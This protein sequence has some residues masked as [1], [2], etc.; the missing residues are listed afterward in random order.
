MLWLAA[1][2]NLIASPPSY[3]AN[4]SGRPSLFCLWRTLALAVFDDYDPH[5]RDSV[6]WFDWKRWAELLAHAW[7]TPSLWGFSW[8]WLPWGAFR[9][10]WATFGAVSWRSMRQRW[11][12]WSQLR[13]ADL[14]PP[15]CSCS[16]RPLAWGWKRSVATCELTWLAPSLGST[17]HP[18]TSAGTDVILCFYCRGNWSFPFKFWPLNISKAKTCLLSLN[19]NRGATIF[20]LHFSHRRL[21]L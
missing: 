15:S 6:S 11:P 17:A 3:C 19:S 21:K 18:R 12:C 7:L 9:G 5:A 2:A 14:F 10:T 16:T 13:A 4:F 1:S 20:Y 8:P